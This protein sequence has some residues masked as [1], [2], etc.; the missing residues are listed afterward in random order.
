[1]EGFEVWNKNMK[2]IY[3][4]FRMLSK[5]AQE[6]GAVS[7]IPED[8]SGY[9]LLFRIPEPTRYE[10]AKM[11]TDISKTSPTIQ[12]FSKM[13]HLTVSDFGI[14]AKKDFVF[15]KSLLDKVSN[16]IGKEIKKNRAPRIHLG[17][18]LYNQNTVVVEG[19]PI[20]NDFYN[21]S[22]GIVGKLQDIESP[23]RFPW[24]SHITISRFY[25]PEKPENLKGFFELIESA[26]SI[27]DEISLNEL[28][29]GSFFWNGY[30]LSW[31]EHK[32]FNLK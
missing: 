30:Q 10:L 12:Y 21:L 8:T 25:K 27:N 24:G 13:L 20:G 17:G 28:E 23:L 1:M 7:T 29:L 22:K 31:E 5:D 14:V 2:E 18:Y 15:S 32:K 16:V 9:Y 11:S 3:N 26:S 4:K 6:K 19:Q